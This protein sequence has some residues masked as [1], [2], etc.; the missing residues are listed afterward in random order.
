M[1]KCLSDT[2]LQSSL[3][4]C[5]FRYMFLILGGGGMQSPPASYFLRPSKRVLI[6][7]WYNPQSTLR[8]HFTFTWATGHCHLLVYF[9]G[10][11]KGHGLPRERMCCLREPPS[12]PSRAIHGSR[13]LL[14]RS[15]LI[16]NSDGNL[17]AFSASSCIQF[18]VRS[19]QNNVNY[20]AFKKKK[21]KNTMRCV[22]TTQRS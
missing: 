4:I 5:F 9:R 3:G 8:A 2:G 15:P 20:S 21:H 19:Y 11:T 14:S 13:R 17:A 10:W 12:V 1:R 16:Q 18:W 22:I 6:R 7:H